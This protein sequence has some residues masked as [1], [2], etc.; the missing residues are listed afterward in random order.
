[1]PPPRTPPA[2]WLS[3]RLLA[4]NVL[5]NVS[6]A[7]LPLVVAL[8][9]IPTLI[10]GMGTER[11]GLLAIIWMGVG[12]FSLFDLGIGWALTKLIA[13]RLGSGRQGELPALTHT[14]LRLMLALGVTAAVLVSLI[15]VWLVEDLLNIPT[16][17][18]P[19][20][21]WSLW[22]LAATLPFVVSTAGLIGILQAHQR[23]PQINAVRIPLG[24][25]NFL[26]PVLALSV[27]PSL[28]ATTLVLA[29]SRIAAWLAY[30]W[31]CRNFFSNSGALHFSR[32]AA[33]TL[34]GFGG[35]VTVTN[36]VG[37]LMVYFDRF[38][39][40]ALLTTSAVAYYITPYEVVT[41]LWIVPD[42]LVG[43]LFPAFTA[44]LV[45]DSRRATF[46][47]LVAARA[48]LITMFVPVAAIVL[49]ADEALAL[50]LGADFARESAP[51]L[52]WLAIGV[53]INSIARLP[54]ITLMGK[55]RPDL[56]AKLHMVEL[57]IYVLALWG[58]IHAFGI[59]GAAAAWTCRITLDTAA[60]F[61]LA[62]YRN[63]ELHGAQRRTAVLVAGACCLLAGFTLLEDVGLRISL[64]AV[65]AVAGAGFAL[66]EIRLIRTGVLW[67]RASDHVSAHDEK[68]L[69]SE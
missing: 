39:I 52:R 20:A 9:A 8:W 28:V 30:R 35:W 37:P 7:G 24:I 65:I 68:L 12:Y 48:L 53:L 6:G 46:L 34:L 45:S 29:T 54:Y 59:V 66:R 57:P 17:L 25:M 56:T 26:G 64:A 55:G 69:Q 67:P 13:E 19:E 61:V 43:V 18:H 10:A 49:F 32:T 1:M 40:G 33:R 62:M 38:V 27:T 47:F 42:A 4:R 50:W 21:L 5:W 51:V 41:R 44:A 58:L 16:A 11:F 23:F 3:G 36:I 15:A 14:G 22:I 60:L 2:E 63:P 31:L